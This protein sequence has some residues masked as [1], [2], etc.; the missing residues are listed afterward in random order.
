MKPS[1]PKPMKHQALSLKHDTK[2]PFVLDTSDAGTG[3]T[4]VR[5]LAFAERRRSGSGRALV[6]CLR[7]LMSN[8]WQADFAKFAPDMK[9]SVAAA[10]KRDKA[11]DADADVYVTNHDAVK[12][13]AAK[14]KSWWQKMNFAELIVDE[15]TAYKHATSKRSRAAAKISKFFERRSCLTATPN[16][17]GICNIWHQV[18]LLDSGKRLGSS[19]YAFRNQ[20]CVPTQVG[21]SQ[22]AIRWDDKEGAEEAVFGLLSDIVIRHKFDECVDIP[23]TFH[24]AVEYQLPPRQ[25]KQY[26]S[27]EIAQLLVLHNTP[28]TVAAKLTGTTA[29]HPKITAINAAAVAT[30]LLQLCSG[31]VY[32]GSGKYHVIDTGRYELI[33]DLVQERKHPLV[34]F[35]WKHQRDELIKE[36]EKRGLSFCV[37]DGDANDD[38]RKAMVMSYQAGRFDVMFAHPKSAGHGLTL[39]KGT[40]TIWT[41]PTYDLEWF[42]QGN[43]RQAR[44]GQTEKTEVIVV[45]AKDTIEEKV[46]EM[47]TKKNERMRNLLD[48]FSSLRPAANDSKLKPA[49]K[50]A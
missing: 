29:P 20:V 19:F 32:D 3:K 28:G 12:W 45:V 17:N 31:A 2:T 16:S 36:A 26:E 44:I 33:L 42:E 1:I 21:R 23:K 18:F 48:L 6:L 27:L 30:K 40:S 47:L 37:L 35:F 14:P 22:N 50:R 8:V 38:E 4:A 43:K 34:F 39:T 11:F 9:V 25:F 41:G 24:H 49:K 5:V 7:T 10:D 46:Y 15:S 13:L